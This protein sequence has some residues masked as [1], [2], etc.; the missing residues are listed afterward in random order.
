MAS[1]WLC[2]MLAASHGGSAARST[3][4]RATGAAG[5]VHATPCALRGRSAARSCAGRASSARA[6]HSA[7]ADGT[8]P[9]H[10]AALCAGDSARPNSSCSFT[11][12]DTEPSSAY[13]EAHRPAARHGE[14]RGSTRRRACAVVSNGRCASTS[15]VVDAVG[16]R[17]R[18]MRRAPARRSR[19]RRTAGGAA[20]ASCAHRV[21]APAMHREATPPPCRDRRSPALR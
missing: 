7:R 10:G 1:R 17:R 18:L 12:A 14:R 6:G 3:G 19:G 11:D 16:V 8:S 9:A 21:D 20:A 13:V 2:V 15:I 5:S 4:L